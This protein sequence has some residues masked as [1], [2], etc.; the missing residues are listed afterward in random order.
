MTHWICTRKGP[1]FFL[2]ADYEDINNAL[3][4]NGPQE[5]KDLAAFILKLLRQNY[6][7]EHDDFLMDYQM[8]VAMMNPK[9][10]KEEN[11]S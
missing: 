4:I 1:Y 9:V 3:I 7:D 11:G 6:P 10:V 2:R 8:N 5:L